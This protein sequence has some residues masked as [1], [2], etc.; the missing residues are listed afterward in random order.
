VRF[1][2]RVTVSFRFG[3]SDKC[4]IK[5]SFGVRAKVGLVLGL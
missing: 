1:S 5:D 4:R 2:D 3:E